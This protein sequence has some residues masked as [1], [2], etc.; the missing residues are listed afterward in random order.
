MKMKVKKTL[1]AVLAVISIC[2]FPLHAAAAALGDVNFDGSVSVSDARIVLR[3]AVG[4]DTLSAEARKLADMDG[5]GSVTVADARAV[6]RVAV[7]LGSAFDTILYKQAHKYWRAGVNDIAEFNILYANL[8]YKSASKWCCYYSVNAVFRPALKQAGYSDKEIERIAPTYFEP[9]RLQKIEEYNSLFKNYGKKFG[10]L[11]NEFKV[12]VPSVLMDYYYR[13]PEAGTVY[14][15]HE[16]FDDLIEKDMYNVSANSSAYK[17]EVGDF[18]FMSNKKQ[19]YYEG[20]PTIDHTAQIIEVYSDGTF[21]CTEGSIIDPDDTNDV[22]PRVRERKYFYNPDLGT[23]QYEKNS[24]VIVLTA[25]KP[26]F[27]H[28]K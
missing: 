22:A 19:T 10:L 13:T 1:G 7:G 20:I 27:S 6:L 3:C 5:D 24:I 17:P 11:K 23:Y 26:N 2:V 16:F 28:D 14:T 12:F 8:L 18:L 21:L 15:L 4:L 25:V 9:E